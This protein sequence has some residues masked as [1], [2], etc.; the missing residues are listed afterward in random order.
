[1]KK[2]AS[3]F[4]LKP[5]HNY[6]LMKMK[7]LLVESIVQSDI[8][9]YYQSSK[10]YLDTFCFHFISLFLHNEH[11]YFFWKT[12]FDV[13]FFLFSYFHC[14]NIGNEITA[15]H[16]E[17]ENATIVRNHGNFMHFYKFWIIFIHKTTFTFILSIIRNKE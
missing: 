9:N 11:L 16:C 2:K 7:K 8:Y 6:N 1:M 15:R 17:I 10:L 14:H 12:S 4:L 13:N 3:K 5:K